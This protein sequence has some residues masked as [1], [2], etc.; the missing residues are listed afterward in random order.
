LKIDES[1]PLG[2]GM[3]GKFYTLKNNGS[4]YSYLNNGVNVGIIPDNEAYRF[5]YIGI[6]IKPKMA[7]SMVYGVENQ[8]R[9]QIVYMADNPMFRSF[10]ESGKL[11]I[12]NAI[13]FVGQ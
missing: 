6:K 2:F 3:G 4:R 1:H 8:G 11:L 10:W 12:S 7:Q 5:G 9:G 13:F